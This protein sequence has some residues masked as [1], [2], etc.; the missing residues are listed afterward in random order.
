MVVHVSVVLVLALLVFSLVHYK[1]T[2]FTHALVCVMFGFF[3]ASTSF[4][5]FVTSTAQ[6]LAS[7]LSGIR[8]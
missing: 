5:P 6:S 2:R 3:L 8:L 1:A 7:A 4:G